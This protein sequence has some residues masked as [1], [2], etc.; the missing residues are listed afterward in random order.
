M[1]RIVLNAEQREAVQA[2]R[3]DPR[4]RPAERDR[5][6]MLLLS[7]AGWAAP[8]IAQ[9]LECS[10]ATVRRF[11]HA[12]QSAGL[13]AIRRRRPGPPPDRARRRQVEAAVRGL[14]RQ[15][16]TWSARQVAVAL[17]EQGVDVSARQMHRYLRGLRARY[18]RTA[19]TLRHKQDPIKVAAAQARLEHRKKVPRLAS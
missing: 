14:L 7:E 3:R 9:H 5:V 11:F 8:R 13:A 2:L 4:L 1:I 12:F 19:R 15:G 18:R 16:R 10:T 6:E 17:R